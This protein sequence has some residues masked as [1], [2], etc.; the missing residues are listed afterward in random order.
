MQNKNKNKCKYSF[1]ETVFC[2]KKFTNNK[3]SKLDFVRFFKES[4]KT[5]TR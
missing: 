4:Y 3:N 1:L 2:L 5:E